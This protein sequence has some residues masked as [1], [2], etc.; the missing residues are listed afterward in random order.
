MKLTDG[1]IV[2]LEGGA[3]VQLTGHLN[4]RW[5]ARPVDP[6]TYRRDDSGAPW[7]VD[8]RI[9][10]RACSAA[11]LYAGSVAAGSEYDPMTARRAR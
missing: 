6:E 7:C 5:F 10:R 3:L 1:D 9:V 8:E 2:E 4:G 11:K